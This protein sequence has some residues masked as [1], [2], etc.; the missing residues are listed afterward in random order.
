MEQ[1]V[2]WSGEVD[3]ARHEELSSAITEILAQPDLTGLVI[4]LSGVTFMDAAGVSLLV[5][6]RNDAQGAGVALELRDLAAPVQ[7]VLRVA[8]LQDVLDSV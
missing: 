5:Q 6:A 1:V 3:Y 2:G 4:D 7:H 8:G